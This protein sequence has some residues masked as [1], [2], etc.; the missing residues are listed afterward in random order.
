MSPGRAARTEPAHSLLY[1]P[2]ALPPVAAPHDIPAL[3]AAI[4]SSLDYPL[5]VRQAD[6]FTRSFE[7]RLSILWGP[8][9][10]GKTTA[11][12]AIVLGWLE[13][14][15]QRERPV[16][17]GIGSSTWQAIDNLL[18]K[19]V[20]VVD[21]MRERNPTWPE[22]QFARVRGDHS[23]PGRNPRVL[24]V[25]R[26][27][28]AAARLVAQ[29]ERGE[30]SFIVAGTWKQLSEL[31]TAQRADEKPLA[32]WFDLLLIDEA[33]QV[34]VA[35]A[36]AY[37]LLMKENGNVV[38]AGDHR[39]LGPIYTFEVQDSMS[40]LLDCIF[41]FARETHRVPET[42]LVENYRTN[43]EIADWPRQRFY[44]EYEAVMPRDRLP[45]SLPEGEPPGWPSSIPWS[46]V[47]LRLLDP[48]LPVVA[49]RYP[50]QTYT[51][52]NP[53]EA[54][55]VAALAHLYR[56]ALGDGQNAA[57]F[58]RHRL[59]IVTPHRAQVANI[60][61]LLLEGTTRFADAWPVVAT[62]DGF[63]GQERDMIAASY[64]V[65]DPDFI[66]AEE[67]F[68]LDPRRFNVTLT[69]ARYKFLLVISDALMEHLPADKDTATNAAY[70]QLFVQQYCD[71]VDERIEVPYLENGVQRT[72]QCRLRGHV[73]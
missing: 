50:A 20:Q 55:V 10:T 48:A 30:T 54:Q 58:W 60:R 26:R 68:I 13:E 37:F 15:A 21:G 64:A 34:K 23:S 52:S 33:S 57:H 53:F 63:Q 8:P 46:H 3:L 59:G 47:W 43:V 56:A 9:G 5:N 1:Q 39:Q 19:A 17:I 22:V 18:D 2:A 70:L 32:C 35:Y 45:I 6:A 36:A 67:K 51:L 7:S 16:I 41:T 12:A 49:I 72:M 66:R 11:L 29:L 31:A 69:R 61:N 40:G 38:L 42:A 28:P 73:R 62:V 65:A 25:P 4:T 14:A 44:P 71:S 27:S 24:D